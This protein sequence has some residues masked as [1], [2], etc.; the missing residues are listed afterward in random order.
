[1][2]GNHQ[3]NGKHSMGDPAHRVNFHVLNGGP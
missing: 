1:V 2:P 3:A